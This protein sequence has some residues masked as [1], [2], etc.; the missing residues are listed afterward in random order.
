MFV[1][2]ELKNE[3]SVVEFDSLD[4]VQVTL[5]RKVQFNHFNSKN[6]VHHSRFISFG[7]IVSEPIDSTGKYL[8]PQF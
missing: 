7:S 5:L 8:I 2:L 1:D 6:K 4:P 3:D